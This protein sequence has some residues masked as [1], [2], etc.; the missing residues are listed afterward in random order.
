MDDA[1]IRNLVARVS[2][3]ER[4][5]VLN[6][7]GSTYTDSLKSV[8]FCKKCP[9]QILSPFDIDPGRLRRKWLKAF[10]AV[11][12]LHQFPIIEHSPCFVTK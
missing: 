6:T 11:S 10:A 9:V 4:A 8:A 12:T 1:T 7:L 2:S 5:H 3:E